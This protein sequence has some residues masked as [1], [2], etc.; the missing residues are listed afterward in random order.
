MAAKGPC[1]TCKWPFRS[2]PSCGSGLYT[3]HV[4][5]SVPRDR[6]T[7]LLV[8]ALA[9]LLAVLAA[10]QYHWTGEIG[11]AEAERGRAR[12]TRSSLGFER[13]LAYELGRALFAFRPQAPGRGGDP[14]LRLQ[15]RLDRLQDAPHA[16]LVSRLT[17]VRISDDGTPLAEQ[18]TPEEPEFVKTAWP[19]ELDALRPVLEDLSEGR[20]PRGGVRPDLLMASPP[21]VVIPHVRPDDEPGRR[22]GARSFRIDGLLLVGLSEDHLK[23]VLLPELA[24]VHFGPPEESDYA[25]AVVRRDGAVLYTSDPE[26]HPEQ[27]SDPDVR[28]GLGLDERFTRDRMD[29]GRG[30][31][32]P[33][34]GRRGPGDL[35]DVALP[36]R[37]PPPD[38]GGP[39]GRRGQTRP[40]DDSPWILLA[41]HRGG[42]LDQ[43]VAAV[44]RRNLGVGLGVLALL[45]TA[46]ALLAAGGARARRLAHQQLE[47]VAGVTH[48]LHT[49]LAAIRSA[50]QNLADGVVAEPGQVRRYGDLIQKEGGRLSAL[51]AQVLDF[52]GIESGSRAYSMEPVR[53][54]EL[55][56]QVTSDLS[57]VL[58][59]AGMALETDVGP[60]LPEI[61]ADPVAL[62]RALENLIT[63]AAKFA[64]EGKWL[65]VA[66]STGADG[67][68]RVRVEDRGPGIPKDDAERVFDPFYRGHNA[69][70][71]QAPGSGLGLGLVRR[72]VHAHGGQV[73][74]DAP[75]LG[76]TA[77]TMVLPPSRES[78]ARA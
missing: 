74:L 65:R 40:V 25:V 61:V 66:V 46:A 75:S 72:I 37:P 63:N 36:G 59:Q 69:R 38:A 68:V 45:G 60:D 21:A 23:R 56:L 14:R 71:R 54:G 18:A 42:S 5:W 31:G 10:L 35:F 11:R 57:L 49:P 29:R 26:S 67:G 8:G 16:G 77:V 6:G 32:R 44:R 2:A 30:P 19:E 20:L 13:Q 15:E 12:L 22:P 58:E 39:R 33:P 28:L 27:W 76:G 7:W 1:K 55:V 78:Q 51:V 24:E 53:M 70:E 4:M 17:L 3:R 47:F 43:A 64:S 73:L 41:R 34:R 50:G 48:E 9:V 62:R 52:A